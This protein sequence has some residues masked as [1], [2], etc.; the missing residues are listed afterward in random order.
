MHKCHLHQMSIIVQ[1]EPQLVQGVADVS[2]QRSANPP[3][4]LLKAPQLREGAT[5]L[6]V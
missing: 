1:Q 3:I 5:T 4:T 2:K 6:Q